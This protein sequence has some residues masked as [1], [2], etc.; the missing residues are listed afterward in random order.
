M[1]DLLKSY[2]HQVVSYH[3]EKVR[4]DLF[5]EIYDGLCEE[6][7]DWQEVNPGSDEE[8]FLDACR[9]HP[10]RFATRLAADDS[11]Y[12]IGPQLYF[13]FISALKTGAVI[14]VVLYIF[15]A[16]V[17]ALGDDHYV[18]S[19]LQV[20]SGIPVTL[21]WV[22]A[23]ILG[24]FIAMEKSGDRAS[25]LDNWTSADL[26][27]MSSHQQISRGETFFDLG[28]S[29]LALLWLTDIV[30]F[31]VMARLDGVWFTDW[32]IL[33]PTWFWVAAGAMLV[34]DVGYSLLRLTKPFWSPRLRL[35][36]IVSN[37]LWFGLLGYAIAQPQLLTVQGQVPQ[38]LTA[39]LP[40]ANKAVDGILIVICIILAWEIALHTWRLT[41]SQVVTIKVR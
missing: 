6:F 24:V 17:S 21:L 34:F 20:L 7:S 9:E 2:A 40:L 12:L 32:T 38:K 11:A 19:F 13:S 23:C 26:K 10:M 14:T 35:T 16:L 1:M 36:T 27:P 8:D 25:W 15:L 5:A 3:P 28:L 39:L 37:L 18:R 30:R 4:N 41:R 29:V 22:S 31:P 33:L